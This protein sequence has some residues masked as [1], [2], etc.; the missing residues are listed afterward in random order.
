M[1]LTMF[2]PVTKGYT[3]VCN[4]VIIKVCYLNHRIYFPVP[5]HTKLTHFLF[6][7]LRDHNSPTFNDIVQGSKILPSP[8]RALL[9]AN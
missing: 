2:L 9:S 7:F 4:T 6:P 1:S 5:S 8:S 3:Q